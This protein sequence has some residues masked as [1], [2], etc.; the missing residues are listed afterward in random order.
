MRDAS[1]GDG[2]FAQKIRRG[3][4]KN[5]LDRQKKEWKRKNS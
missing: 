2:K 1:S 4:L 5:R 3:R